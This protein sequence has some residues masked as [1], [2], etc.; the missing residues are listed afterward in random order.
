MSMPRGAGG[1]PPPV[2][3][4][5]G[6]SDYASPCV[7]ERVLLG[8]IGTPGFH[9]P[10]QMSNAT[11]TSQRRHKA[12]SAMDDARSEDAFGT[13]GEIPLCDMDERT[14]ADC[15]ATKP[16]EATAMAQQVAM[17]TRQPDF[18]GASSE[19]PEPACGSSKSSSCSSRSGGSEGSS[20]LFLAKNEAGCAGSSSSS[21]PNGSPPPSSSKLFVTARDDASGSEQEGEFFDDAA[22]QDVYPKRGESDLHFHSEF[23]EQENDNCYE[24]GFSKSTSTSSAGVPAVVPLL[25]PEP[26]PHTSSHG[27]YP[28]EGDVEEDDGPASGTV[29]IPP[30]DYGRSRGAQD[31]LQDRTRGNENDVVK[32]PISATQT[33]RSSPASEHSYCSSQVE[34][35]LP[36]PSSARKR[37]QAASP[38][39]ISTGKPLSSCED[40]ST[41]FQPSTI[42]RPN[43]VSPFDAVILNELAS[44][45]EAQAG[46][47]AAI[48][49]KVGAANP[50]VRTTT[51][52]N[53][54]TGFPSPTQS[55]VLGAAATQQLRQQR[56]WAR[57]TNTSSSS[58]T[59]QE[60]PAAALRK[61]SPS[62]G[63][64]TLPNSKVNITQTRASVGKIPFPPFS[65]VG[66]LVSCSS[67]KAEKP[68]LLHVAAAQSRAASET[69]GWRVPNF[70]IGNRA[71]CKREESAPCGPAKQVHRTTHVFT[72][73]PPP[74]FPQLLHEPVM[75]CKRALSWRG[76]RVL[77]PITPVPRGGFGPRQPDIGT[78]FEKFLDHKQRY[79]SASVTRTK[80]R[81][82]PAA[83]C[84]AG[85]EKTKQLQEENAISSGSPPPPGD[86]QNPSQ[87]CDRATTTRNKT[88]STST[89]TVTTAK[90]KDPQTT[91]TDAARVVENNARETLPANACSAGGVPLLAEEK[92]KSAN[93]NFS[94]SS[95]DEN[96]QQPSGTTS[97]ASSSSGRIEAQR[98][99]S[100]AA[101]K[102]TT[103]VTTGSLH[104]NLLLTGTT[105]GGRGRPPPSTTHRVVTGMTSSAAVASGAVSRGTSQSSTAGATRRLA[106]S[107]NCSREASLKRGVCYWHH[108]PYSSVSH[109][110]RGFATRAGGQPPQA[111]MIPAQKLLVPTI[112]AGGAVT[113]QQ[114][115]Q[116]TV[117]SSRIYE[118]PQQQAPKSEET[119]GIIT[120]QQPPFSSGT[121]G[122]QWQRARPSWSVSGKLNPSPSPGRIVPGSG[123]SGARHSPLGQTN[124][125]PFSPSAAVTLPSPTRMPSGW[126]AHG[127]PIKTSVTA[128][129]PGTTASAAAG[130]AG[131][132]IP[133]AA[134]ACNITTTT[135][136]FS[137]NEPL[138]QS[139]QIRSSA[140]IRSNTILAASAV[141]ASVPVATRQAMLQAH[142]PPAGA[143]RLCVGS[144]LAPRIP[145]V[146]A[147]PTRGRAPVQ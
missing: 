63:N 8:A 126:P 79:A 133:Q 91:S 121:G 73:K 145:F 19:A 131:P 138:S 39:S 125:R 36:P 112:G 27:I 11:P 102:T 62:P 6:A 88:V 97:S 4:G 17:S 18:G 118:Q 139:M 140:S 128:I 69:R 13:P 130:A 78:P 26:G 42:I 144:V 66:S 71:S 49:G 109:R 37:I 113:Q 117:P 92:S 103:V 99:F 45:K 106:S 40:D 77:P 98:L 53:K 82:F 23:S 34:A 87:K 108:S 147:A 115:G 20:S 104:R 146:F 84:V 47:R 122:V 59:L 83:A 136:S 1:P 24:E 28:D 44:L 75:P 76:E 110:L 141:P 30:P 111:Q 95:S 107:N 57:T 32:I 137:S 61:G 46:N 58:S 51:G 116:G 16:R 142:Q 81:T 7:S 86:L 85:G 94:T 41:S 80:R 10:G 119:S 48:N 31:S 2:G 134:D 65:T 143:P 127:P 12:G 135:S 56:P 50:V 101:T 33:K 123:R 29:T 3:C 100:Q 9:T 14:G 60:P 25:G 15:V 72:I 21:Y 54:A 38:T 35:L 132:A 105:V 64:T 70:S 120:P 43:S 74:P 114:P 67:P 89:S 124:F 129:P 93:A 68:L 96:K 22:L 5:D 90:T 55:V 52:G